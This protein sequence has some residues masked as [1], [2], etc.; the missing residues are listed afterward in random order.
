[1][2]Q[3]DTMSFASLVNS[4]DSALYRAKNAGKNRVFMALNKGERRH[5]DAP[6]IESSEYR[7]HLDTES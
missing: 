2:L 5:L 7:L 6:V 3:D 4:A 1:M